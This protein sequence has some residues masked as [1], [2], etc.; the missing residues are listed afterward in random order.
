VYHWANTL[1]ATQQQGVICGPH[2][3]GDVGEENCSKGG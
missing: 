1:C 3:Q 2:K